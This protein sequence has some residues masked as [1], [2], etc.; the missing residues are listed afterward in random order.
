MRRDP[1]NIRRLRAGAGF[2]R[3]WGS[4]K[5]LIEWEQG[6]RLKFAKNLPQFLF[7]SINSVEEIPAIDHEPTR[8]ELPIGAEEKVIAEQPMLEI[9]ESSSCNEAK[10]S[11]IFF[12]FAAPR[13]GALA[14]SMWFNRHSADV[15]F[16]SYTADKTVIADSKN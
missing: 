3:P 9:I 15:P 7:D 10:I 1:A 12:V 4:A 16:L 11:D 6:I 13:F 8:A 5:V 2:R 14:A